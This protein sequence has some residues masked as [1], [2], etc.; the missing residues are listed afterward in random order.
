MVRSGPAKP[1]K[2]VQWTVLSD[3]RREL[4]RAAPIGRWAVVQAQRFN[5]V[6]I[7]SMS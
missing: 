5:L 3:E 7:C 2:T 1:G 4:G 6:S